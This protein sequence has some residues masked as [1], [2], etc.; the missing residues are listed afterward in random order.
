MLK[1][2]FP[3]ILL[4]LVF[5]AM[6]VVLFNIP[7]SVP[8]PAAPFVPEQEEETNG[9]T[10]RVVMPGFDDNYILENSAERDLDQLEKFLQGRAAGLHYLA[11]EHFKKL[12]KNHKHSK[13]RKSGDSSADDIVVGVRMTLDSLGRFKLNEFVFSNTDDEEFKENLVNHVEYY[14]RYP[15]SASGTLEFWI[16]IRW[17]EK[18]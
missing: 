3:L 1:R 18:Y 13:A 4:F 10:G 15:K 7:R 5:A 16:P 12:K 2:N 17:M 6:L 11:A 8:K 9:F 14:W